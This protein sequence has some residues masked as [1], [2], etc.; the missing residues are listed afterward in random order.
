MVALSLGIFF[1]LVGIKNATGEPR[2]WFGFDPLLD[3]LEILAVASGL[4]GGPELLRLVVGE[5]HPVLAMDGR[6]GW[7]AQSWRDVRSRPK[8]VLKSSLVGWLVGVMPGVGGSVS[9][10]LAYAWSGAARPGPRDVS[11]RLDGVIAAE[12]SN[13]AKE[14]G[15]LVPTLTL[16]MPGGAGMSVLIGAFMM[17]GIAPGPQL[18]AT[19]PELVIGLAFGL[20]V[21]NVLGGGLV[22][23]GA[24]AFVWLL[25]VP[26][27]VLAPIAITLTA[28]GVLGVRGELFDLWTAAFFC[29]LGVAMIAFGYSRPAFIM[30]FVLAPVIETYGS[31]SYQAYGWA[32][33]LRPGVLLAIA[34]AIVMLVTAGRRLSGARS[35][36]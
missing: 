27:T 20:L 8:I 10:F 34:V 32:F 25:R 33:L 2:L 26:S 18:I 29:A 7:I 30:G 31:I 24:S 12:A 19:Y 4:F 1:G 17:Y 15:D 21:S 36:Q 23:F 6:K 13:N 5:G 11:L 22:A 28:A 16:G 3:G 9:S 35:A 14:G